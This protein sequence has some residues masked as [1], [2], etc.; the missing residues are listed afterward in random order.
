MTAIQ[1]IKQV[2]TQYNVPYRF[3]TAKFHALV[4]AKDAEDAKQRAL[5]SFK[6]EAYPMDRIEILGAVPHSLVE[7]V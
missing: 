4:M 5:A 2:L 3:G 6:R 7:G 1:Q